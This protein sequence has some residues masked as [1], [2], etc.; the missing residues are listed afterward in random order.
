MKHRKNHLESQMGFVVHKMIRYLELY[1]QADS[2]LHGR[3]TGDDGY[4]KDS[5]WQILDGLQGLL[6][7]ELGTYEA[8]NLHRRLN[9]LA[10][11]HRITESKE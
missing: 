7:G 4:I 2:E 10:K 5:V 3:P 1:C 9:A 8:I 11:A 6:N